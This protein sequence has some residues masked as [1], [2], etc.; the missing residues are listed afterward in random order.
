MKTGILHFDEL[1]PMM[2][3]LGWPNEIPVVSGKYD[4]DYDVREEMVDAG[5]V[6]KTKRHQ[7]DKAGALGMRPY[8][9]HALSL[10]LGVNQVAIDRAGGKIIWDDGPEV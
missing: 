3:S 1:P 8:H 4:H 5:I 6:E 10:P 9:Q 7:F 2:A